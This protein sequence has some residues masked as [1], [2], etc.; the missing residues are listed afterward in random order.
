MKKNVFEMVVAMVNGREVADMETLRNEI[1]AEYERM[2]AKRQANQ[3]VYTAAHDVLMGALTDKE[4]TSKELFERNEWP[5]GFTQGKLNYAL[6]AMWADE[7]RK[8]DNGKS[9]NTYTRK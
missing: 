5:E 9:A 7:V 8:I 6:R 3:D 2:N 1:N 4:Q